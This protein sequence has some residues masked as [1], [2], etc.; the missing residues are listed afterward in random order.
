MIGME[1]VSPDGTP[2]GE[3]AVALMKNALKKGLIL[4]SDSPTSN[5]IAFAPPFVISEE[6]MAF[7][8]ATL[9]SH[10]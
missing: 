6:E 9:Q 5:V 2:D 10:L 1:I 7:V 4:L 8:V 3:F